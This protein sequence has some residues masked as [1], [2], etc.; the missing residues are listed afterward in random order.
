MIR[1][2]ILVAI[3]TLDG[4]SEFLI[5]ERRALTTAGIMKSLLELLWFRL[6]RLKAVQL[7]MKTYGIPYL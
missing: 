3:I 5:L 7:L 6:S 2:T 1:K 4:M